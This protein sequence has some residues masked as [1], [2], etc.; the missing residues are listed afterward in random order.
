[1][2]F[3]SRLEYGSCVY[4]IMHMLIKQDL[5]VGTIPTVSECF[6]RSNLS[7][8]LDVPIVLNV[9]RGALTAAEDL[10]NFCL[11]AISKAPLL[12]GGDIRHMNNATLGTLSNPEVIA[13]NQDPLGVQGKRVAFALSQLSNTSSN[14]IS[15][16]CSTSI[17][18]R[19]Q[20]W[21]YDSE[22]GS[23]RSAY[24]GQ[25]LSIE[26]CSTANG[27]NIIVSDCH[28]DDKQTP[29][30]GKNQKWNLAQYHQDINSQLDG[31]W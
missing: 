10:A 7:R 8:S 2:L 29:C 25:C 27:A 5:A 13:V 1:M 28:I 30:S 12:V 18:P 20:L 21:K 16:N 11:W 24:N 19:R 17:D 22:V 14:V 26:S 6:M 3:F 4:R 15:S 9:G 31:L 23:I